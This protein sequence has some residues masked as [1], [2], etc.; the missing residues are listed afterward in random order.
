VGE[1]GGQVCYKAVG[2][3]PRAGF[4]PHLY[5]PEHNADPD[6]DRDPPWAWGDPTRAFSDDV[7]GV[8]AHVSVHPLGGLSAC[9]PCF[10]SGLSVRLPVCF[11]CLSFY[12]FFSLFMRPTVY[13]SV[14]LS[15]CLF[16]YLSFLG[17]VCHFV[18]MHT[19]LCVHLCV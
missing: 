1:Y 12:L 5:P 9:P 10:H 18:R 8:S 13:L 11:S 4:D 15:V 16:V 7:L 19:H 6:P 3:S 2:A 17:C 14:C